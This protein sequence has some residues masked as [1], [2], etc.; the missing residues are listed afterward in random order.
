MHFLPTVLILINMFTQ[1]FTG[2]YCVSGIISDAWDTFVNK[3]EKKIPAL[4]M[5]TY[6]YSSPFFWGGGADLLFPDSIT[7]P[8][9]ANAF[10]MLMFSEALWTFFFPYTFSLCNTFG[11]NY[12]LY[13]AL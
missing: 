1:L 13:I 2:L 12:L 7:H 6:S 8:P 10:E 4:R 3:T 9:S 11:F 5:F